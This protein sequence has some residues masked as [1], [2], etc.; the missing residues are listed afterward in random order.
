MRA[1]SLAVTSSEL[2]MARVY[3]LLRLPKFVKA[4]TRSRRDV[5]I[6]WIMI[7]ERR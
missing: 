6:D 4:A 1:K 2:G 5:P 3:D 7:D